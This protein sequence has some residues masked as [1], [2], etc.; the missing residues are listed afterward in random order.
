MNLHRYYS[1]FFQANAGSPQIM[2][3]QGAMTIREVARCME[4]DVKGV[5]SDIHALLKAGI[6]NK[7]T[8]GK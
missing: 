3:G 1:I 8:E 7:T 2:T 4:R 6:L 5:H